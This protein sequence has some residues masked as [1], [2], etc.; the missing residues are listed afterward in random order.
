M[1]NVVV[2]VGCCKEETLHG[3]QQATGAEPAVIHWKDQL[4]SE[5]WHVM[6]LRL[7]VNGMLLP[8]PSVLCR[9]R[10]NGAMLLLSPDMGFF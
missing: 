1:S 4:N 9:T 8:A 7:E 10:V 3:E 6:E 2:G 5:A